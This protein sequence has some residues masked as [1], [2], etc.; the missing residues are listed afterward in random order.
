MSLSG[1]YK[2]NHDLTASSLS[3]LP[4]EITSGHRTTNPTFFRADEQTR[5]DAL[6]DAALAWM[7]ASPY[8]SVMSALELA[9]EP[10][11]YTDDQFSTLRAYYQ[12]SYEKA[13]KLATPI[14]VQ[15]HHGCVRDAPL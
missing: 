5:S 2:S 4:G 11:P 6:V 1:P 15:F 12:R 3:A 8:S 13:S 9:N 10:R 7:S 14:P